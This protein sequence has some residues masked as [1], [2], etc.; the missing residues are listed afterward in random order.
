MKS[1]WRHV[2]PISMQNVDLRESLSELILYAKPD[3]F[4]YAG[5]K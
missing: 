4:A 1:E 5:V 3:L 2:R